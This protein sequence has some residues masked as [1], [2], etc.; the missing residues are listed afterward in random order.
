MGVHYCE[1]TQTLYVADTYN[2]KIKI[3]QGSPSTKSPLKD[4]IGTSAERNPTV[5]D[6]SGDKV[7][8]NEPNGCWTKYKNGKVEGLYVAD[9]GNNCVR[10]VDNDGNVTTLDFKG[11][12]D[13]REACSEGVC[14]PVF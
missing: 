14:K 6:G 7:R 8:L 11:I 13:A 12:P 2:H 3:I 5:I 9:T 4:W 1:T 10:F